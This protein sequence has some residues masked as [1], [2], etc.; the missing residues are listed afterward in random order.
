MSGAS[1]VPSA[2][3]RLSEVIAEYLKALLYEGGLSAARPLTESRF[4]SPT[5]DERTPL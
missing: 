2:D 1:G 5:K 4:C 3:R